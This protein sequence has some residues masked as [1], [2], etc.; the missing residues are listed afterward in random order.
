M[1]GYNFVSPGSGFDGTFPFVAADFF[2]SGP[3]GN[4]VAVAAADWWKVVVVCF[5]PDPIVGLAC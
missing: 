5:V 2:V 1:N 3:A 4:A